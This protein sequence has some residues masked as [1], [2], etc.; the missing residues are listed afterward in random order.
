ME[1]I[2]I[3]NRQ[4]DGHRGAMTA[5]SI[6]RT[7]AAAAAATDRS[8]AAAVPPPPL[9]LLLLSLPEIAALADDVGSANNV[10]NG[11]EN[12]HFLKSVLSTGESVKRFVLNDWLSLSRTVKIRRA[13]L[14]C[15]YVLCPRS[16]AD[17]HNDYRGRSVPHSHRHWQ[18]HLLRTF[19]F[20]RQ[21]VLHPSSSTLVADL[22]S[23]SA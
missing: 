18:W 19:S 3:H 2:T 14:V 8:L 23:F 20:H 15:A 10:T 22:I 11:D 5:P 6:A 12:W 16:G 1:A 4:M 21:D 17:Y 13:A 7:A 9:L